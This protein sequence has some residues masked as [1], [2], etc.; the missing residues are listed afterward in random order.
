MKRVIFALLSMALA[1]ASFAPKAFTQAQTT[2]T[3]Q[4]IPFKTGVFNP[5][6]GQIFSISGVLISRKP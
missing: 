3:V 4:N 5:C 1:E 6:N 2:T